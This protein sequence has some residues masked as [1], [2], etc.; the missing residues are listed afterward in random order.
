M[1]YGMIDTALITV[2]A[3]SGGDGRVSF[4]REKY[5][6]KGGPDGG[7]GGKGGDV[8]FEA[9]PSLA[10]LMDFRSKV[11]YRAL[12]GEEGGKKLMQGA[13]SKD[14]I[15]KVP[16]GTLVY[17]LKDS[18]EDL[19]ADLT[20]PGQKFLIARG[21]RGGKGNATF[22]SSI[23]QAPRQ[24]TKGEKGDYKKIK[25]E[26]KL[27]ADV[28]LV[29]FPN[30]GKS[31]LINSLAGINVKVANYLFTTLKPNLGVVNLKNGDTAIIADIPGLIEGASKGR[32][33]G[34]DFLK[35]IERTRIIIH[36][37]DPTN[38]LYNYSSDLLVSNSLSQYRIIRR[39]LMNYKS[40][41]T[42]LSEKKEIIAIN[43]I[44]LTEL[45]DASADIKSAFTEEGL[46]VVF[47]SAYTGENLELLLEKVMI[48]LNEIPKES[49]EIEQK[50]YKKFDIEN[51]PNRKFVFGNEPDIKEV[52]LNYKNW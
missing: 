45:R 46:D 4:R 51:L 49:F 42:S 26:V 2:K 39:E 52:D 32:G 16:V 37:I 28:G 38:N 6:P 5:V 41:L 7:N 40:R 19:V 18:G 29:G 17:E 3:G 25:L 47:I 11:D 35:H 1:N 50:I 8:Y 12:D 10:T 9:D 23:N 20:M 27:I 21:G 33:L 14:L 44:D 13:S 24:F 22:K 36:V 48:L 43:K 34:D 31:T 15:I 30:A